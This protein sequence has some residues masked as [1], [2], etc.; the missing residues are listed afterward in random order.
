MQ[1]FLILLA[2][3]AAAVFAYL[4]WF[5]SKASGYS[6]A[7]VEQQPIPKREFYE[8]WR[9]VGLQECDTRDQGPSQLAPAPC[10]DYVLAK[11][12]RCVASAGSS[13]PA[14]IASKAESR[15]L[16][17]L[18]LECVQPMPH[19]NGVEVRTFEE[20]RRHCPP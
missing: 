3:L 15:R 8:L 10:R 11:H 7:R 17:H 20:A 13:A 9:E 12:D 16:A 1:R 4:H 6:L 5:G 2:L 19:C 18:Y 14:Q